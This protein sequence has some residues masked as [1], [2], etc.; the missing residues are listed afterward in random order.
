MSEYTIYLTTE[1]MQAITRYDLTFD[2][3]M[4]DLATE[5]LDLSCPKP[6]RYTLEDLYQALI[7]LQ[8]VNPII[9]NFT[10]FWFIPVMR[11]HSAFGLDEICLAPEDGEYVDDSMPEELSCY[12]GLDLSDNA[13]FFEVWFTIEKCMYGAIQNKETYMLLSEYLDINPLLDVIERHFRNRTKPILEWEFTDDEMRAY[14]E[15]FTKA[16]YLNDVN[17]EELTLARHFVEILI[18]KKD[19][20]ALRAKA[21]ASYGGDRLYPCNWILAKD[22]LLTLT[23]IDD[24]PEYAN[25]L[26]YIY[27]YGRC[28]D[29]VPDYEKSLHYYGIAAANGIYEGIYKLADQYAYGYGCEKQPRSAVQLYKMVYADSLKYFLKGDHAN[30]ADAALRIGHA[31]AE[32]IYVEPNKE[33]A[34]F[35]YLQ[36][37][38]AA[39]IRD[40]DTDFFGYSEV[41]K[42]S[43]EALEN[44]EDQMDP[45]F[46]S[47]YVDYEWPH[48]LAQLCAD[49]NRCT[50]HYEK[51]P[52][53]TLSL[54][55]ARIP[56]RS[57]PEPDFVLFTIPE[58][59]YC[60]RS[61]EIT[62][63]LPEDT[64]IWF[65]DDA[66]H[67]RY[68]AINY[69]QDFGL[70]EIYYDDEIV[71]K[72]MSN[73]YRIESHR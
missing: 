71:G 15:P 26:G 4:K 33:I 44:M 49:N 72:I 35:H 58:L 5:E 9:S 68:D 25:T 56:T 46:F 64:S 18:A 12:H 8:K 39:E 70:L 31:Y 51:D 32:G 16:E 63:S 38:Y 67:I 42:H 10:D 66:D 2:T 62:Y 45:D 73:N 24:D 50:L 7:T 22:C 27:Y 28:S 17:E 40:A 30:F 61:Y 55:G 52:E 3:L 57:V 54:T 21:F 29:G 23:E 41:V 47:D 34:L 11:L 37:L 43:K 36:A 19:K 20:T 1:Q 60:M 53:G 13:I 59:H 48:F 65:K 69:N 14:I 6:Y